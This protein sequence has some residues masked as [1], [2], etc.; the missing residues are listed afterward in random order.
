MVHFEESDIAEEQIKEWITKYNQL[1][2]FIM[3]WNKVREHD[4]LSKYNRLL[5]KWIILTSLLINSGKYF[6][7]W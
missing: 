2:L 5:F 7:N 1:M 3:L 4:Y 6:I